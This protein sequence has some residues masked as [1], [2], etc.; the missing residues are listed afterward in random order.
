MSKKIEDTNKFLK[1]IADDNRLRILLFLQSSPKCVCNIFPLLKI[2]QKLTS[3][4]LAQLRDMNLVKQKR[5]GNFI[6][7][8]INKK[9]LKRCMDNLNSIIKI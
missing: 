1:V 6:H 7:Y 4:H 5:E 2:S 8:S 9:V 3:H